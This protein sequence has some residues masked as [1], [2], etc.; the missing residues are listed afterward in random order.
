MLL[1]GREMS[2]RGIDCEYWFCK[3][4]NRLAE[5]VETG[6]A[7][8]G[9]LSR[10][11]ERLDRGEFD[12][13]HMTASDP[14]AELV[15]RMA[16]G[17]ARVVVTARGAL[18][19]NWSHTNCVAYTAISRGMAE[20]NQPYTDLQIEVVRNAIDVDRFSPPSAES[21]GPP[22]VAFVGRTTAP[23]KDF[24]RFTRIARRLAAHGARIWI[25]DPH[26]SK[27]EAFL[28]Q[29]AEPLVPE[30]WE[31][32]PFGEIPA[33]YRAVASSGGV[34]LM[35]SRSEGFG[36]V[37]PEAAACGAR[38]AAPDVI[39]LRE[40]IIDGVTGMLF[41]AAAPDDDVAARLQEWID[42]PHDMQRCSDATRAAFSSG[43]LAD[44]YAEIYART[45]P[46][47]VTAAAARREMPELDTL[48]D[49][50]RRQHGWRASASRDGA[51]DL[52][53]AGFADFSL[54]A[55]SIAFRNAPRQFLTRS[56]SRQLLATLRR[57]TSRTTVR[58][59]ASR[60]GRQ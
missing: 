33:F 29:G 56:G 13:V 35:T 51:E 26:E 1:L 23:E 41:A 18:S 4:S 43:V 44:A 32:V 37:A 2:R 57:I 11:A 53:N 54:G 38:V 52:A 45:Q 25:A 10:L 55:L 60:M 30:R 14:A 6:R 34:V 24:P 59:M 47:L 20:V 19:D 40:A 58:R 17:T 46:R 39:G 31:R 48:R 8:L 27:L 36:N 42:G 28:E 49:H 3:G 9:P 22:I 12:V 15:A 7:T 50:L 5:F 21:G 16:R